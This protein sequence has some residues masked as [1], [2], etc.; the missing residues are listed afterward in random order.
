MKPL[1]IG[2]SEHR[3]KRSLDP[4]GQQAFDLVGPAR[5][6]AKYALKGVPE[7]ARRFE[8]IVDLGCDDRLALAYLTKRQTDAARPVI[9]MK[10]HAVVPLELTPGRGRIDVHILKV[11]IG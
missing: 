1:V 9:R 6:R 8:S 5:R 11:L 10:G 3:T 4:P 2:Q 7:S